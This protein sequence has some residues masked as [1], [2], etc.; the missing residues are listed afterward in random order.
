MNFLPVCIVSSAS[1]FSIVCPSL[2]KAGREPLLQVLLHGY[3][4]IVGRKW[5]SCHVDVMICKGET[6]PLQ[7]N[8]SNISI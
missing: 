1:F 5:L 4:I 2:G 7:E 6:L 3:I 8:I